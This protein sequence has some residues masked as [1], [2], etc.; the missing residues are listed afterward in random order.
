MD[1]ALRS[2]V[3]ACRENDLS[4]EAVGT[5]ESAISNYLNLSSVIL[6]KHETDN[7]SSIALKKL[8]QSVKVFEEKVFQHVQDLVRLL[9]ERTLG[10]Q[11]IMWFSEEDLQQDCVQE[12]CMVCEFR[13]QEL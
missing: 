2:A 1:E 8:L 4:L 6:A 7:C 9:S 10:Q 3:S 5:I 13:L 11:R 12:C